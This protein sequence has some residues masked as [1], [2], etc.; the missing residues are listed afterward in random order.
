MNCSKIKKHIKGYTYLVSIGEEGPRLKNGLPRAI[1]FSYLPKSR[2]LEANDRNNEDLLKLQMNSHSISTET[3]TLI[4]G[5]Y[6]INQITSDIES[7]E[8]LAYPML[9]KETDDLFLVAERF[10]TSV[11]FEL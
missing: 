1:V 11:V 7:L 4:K 6:S 5:N 2:N 8:I 10:E 3:K 9:Y